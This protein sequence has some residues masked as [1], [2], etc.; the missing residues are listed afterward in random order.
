MFFAVSPGVAN[1]IGGFLTQYFGWQSSFYFLAIYNV[2]VIVMVFGMPETLNK[3]LKTPLKLS[4]VVA[5]YY[6]ASK[7]LTVVI[8]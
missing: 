2:V 1:F 5:G 3:S 8:N 7:N 6:N 4:V